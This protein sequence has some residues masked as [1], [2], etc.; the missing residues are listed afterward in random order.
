M[1]VNYNSLS[2]RERRAAQKLAKKLLRTTTAES[3][4]PGS[5]R[6]ALSTAFMKPENVVAA[7]T[8]DDGD[9]NWWGDVVLRKG[10]GTVQ[11]G[12][13][14]SEPC[15]SKE[16]ALDRV[17]HQIA[18]IK[19]MREHPLV[20]K[21]RADGIDPESIELLRVHHKRFGCRYIMRTDKEIASESEAFGRTH[22]LDDSA[23]EFDIQCAAREASAIISQYAA[24]FAG[25]PEFLVPPWDTD[26]SVSEVNQV[27]EA[28]SFLL[29]QGIANTDEWDAN[30]FIIGNAQSL[31]D[32]D[33]MG[34]FL[35]PISPP[36]DLPLN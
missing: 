6:G 22:G 31:P 1:I 28:A 24:K 8:Y 12:V 18:G 26:K 14:E 16:E 27:R 2:R 7:F 11:F 20:A 10:Q 21:L 9:G 23:D 15:R 34:A 29:G 36:G 32:E 25:D 30:R 13:A 4:S 33:G 17:K 19:A 5:V 3:F 35:I